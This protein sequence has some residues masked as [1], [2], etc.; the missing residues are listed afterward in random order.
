MDNSKIDTNNLRQAI[1]VILFLLVPLIVTSSDFAQANSTPAY[2]Q[3]ESAVKIF[4]PFVTD[5][6]E[7]ETIDDVESTYD[8]TRIYRG[9]DGH[10]LYLTKTDDVVTGFGEHPDQ[11]YAYVLR[12]T[13]DG[14]RIHADFWDIPKGSRE[15]T[16]TIELQISQEGARLVRKSGSEPI[17]A[18]TWQEIN[19]NAIPWPGPQEAGF[20]GLDDSDMSGRFNFGTGDS[21]YVRQ[22][23]NTIISVAES[24]VT[25]NGRPYKVSVYVGQRA[26]LTMDVSPLG[27][28][29]IEAIGTYVTVPKGIADEFGTYALNII[30]NRRAML[31]HNNVYLGMLEPDYTIDWDVFADY[32]DNELAGEV[33]GYGYAIGQGDTLMRANAGGYRQLA[34]DTEDG[35]A[36][37]FTTETQA[38]AFSTSKTVTAIAMVKALHER[39]LSVDDKI[40]PFLPPCWVQGDN[41]DDIS[42]RH[43]MAHTSGLSGAKDGSTSYVYLRN[44][45]A[46]GSESVPASYNYNN[47]AYELMRYLVPI[48]NQ[49]GTLLLFTPEDCALNGLIL[50]GI[51]SQMFE[52]YIIEEVVEPTGGTAAFRPTGDNVAYLYSLYNPHV[53]GIGPNENGWLSAGAGYLAISPLS[54]QKL[55]SALDQGEIFPQELVQEMYDGRLGFDGPTFGELGEYHGKDG[56]PPTSRCNIDGRSQVLIYPEGVHAWVTINSHAAYEHLNWYFDG[57][58]DA[59]YSGPLDWGKAG[60]TP[61]VG[62]F[63]QDGLVNDIVAF[64]SSAANWYINYDA[65]SSGDQTVLNW[66]TCGDKPV[67]GDFDR[68]GFSDDLAL[69]RD[70]TGQWFFDTDLDGVNDFV[71]N[72]WGTKFD[73]PV[74]GDFDGDG[75]D[76]DVA[77]FRGSNGRWYFDFDFTGNTDVE[78]GPWGLNGDRAIAGD[79]D[80]D[81]S[82]DD[83]GLYR[84]TNQTLYFDYNGNGNVD[85]SRANAGQRKDIPIAGDFNADGL[86]NGIGMVRST[87]PSLAALLRDAFDAALK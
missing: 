63:D 79:F 30:A 39:G 69:F 45:I 80:D 68:D 64:R 48:V 28:I 35:V 44:M 54:F 27:P 86:V 11:D 66:G 22:V 41:V 29:K 76:D 83:I 52:T 55:L 26:N 34:V 36:L 65:D 50:N 18:T 6:L 47:L 15:A 4:L 21:H 10:A 7:P 84:G 5:G 12:G 62:D 46:N 87:S 43:I 56:R 38:Q 24:G 1:I 8:I 20:Q 42:F 82:R 71:I 32:I 59:I 31:I 51:I 33:I 72:G 14:D 73:Q 67:V 3:D 78:M 60:D 61:V 40:A 53:A 57:N 37:P 77:L 23:G 58:G 25:V 13:I 49:P 70:D 75:F 16:G 81:G 17:G 9:N 2:A 74:A 85:D 19:P